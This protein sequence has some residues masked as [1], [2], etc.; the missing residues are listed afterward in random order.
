[1]LST[2][3]KDAFLRHYAI[4]FS[5]SMVVAAL[6]YFFYPILSRML[7]PSD[8]GDVQ[9]FIS[10]ITQAGIL[11]GAFT[12]VAVNIT[13]N[14]VENPA[15]KAGVAV[16]ERNAILTE[17]QR[18]CFWIVCVV[19]VVLL[20]GATHL[21]TFLNLSSVYPLLGLIAVLSL[22][23]NATFRNAF[24]QGTSKFFE[25]S[26]SGL[27][28]S[29]G[30]IIFAVLLVWLGLT[31]TGA[32]AGLVL[33]Q[34]AVLYYLFMRTRSQLDLN[35]RANIHVLEKGVIKN[36]LLYGLLVIFATGLVTFLYTSDVLIVKHLFDPHV[37]GLYSGISAIAKI[38]F[39]LL[40]PV[41]AV[42]FAS[43]KIKNTSSENHK[44]M[45]K[46]LG[47]SAALGI[48]VLLI[49]YVFNDITVKV[50]LGGNY[51]GSAYLLP[52]VGLI[53]LLSSLVNIFVY[54]F[55][56]LRRFFLI[57]LSFFG[58]LLAV[59]LLMVKH[60]SID[61]ILNDLLVSAAI[62]IVLLTF[63]YVKD[64]ISSHTSLQ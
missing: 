6:N 64:H 17:L 37:A 34:A 15:D 29:A 45:L 62:L 28:S 41:V 5:W 16:N 51:L 25:L 55:L 50:L 27:V 47:I 8:F 2:L 7:S 38:V 58:V 1:M 59:V 32:I 10:L 63:F 9:V 39:F 23:T 40:S 14:T 30:R 21:K 56:A 13:A 4:Y 24:L 61:A 42:L 35:S 49:F 43:I 12:I 54:Y 36:E 48:F 31:S 33:A 3:K 53:M 60:G 46:S 52:K 22:T 44:I 18:I 20:G 26:M 11:F 19:S 57:G